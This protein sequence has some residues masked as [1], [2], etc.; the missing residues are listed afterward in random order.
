MTEQAT[1][2]NLNDLASDH[3][4]RM[5]NLRDLLIHIADFALNELPHQSAPTRAI[6]AMAYAAKEIAIQAAA[7]AQQLNV[8]GSM[9]GFSLM[10]I[11]EAGIESQLDALP[12]QPRAPLTPE[13]IDTCARSLSA[14]LDAYL[15]TAMSQPQTAVSAP[16]AT[17]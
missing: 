17:N 15:R 12:D 11:P 10:A 3:D 5:D 14:G 9:C 7:E 13:E 1:S 2:I 4:W 16:S 8:G 6:T